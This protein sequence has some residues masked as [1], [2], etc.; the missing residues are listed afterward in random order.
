MIGVEVL[1]ILYIMYVSKAGAE[2]ML[3]GD[4]WVAQDSA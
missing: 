1:W 3:F 4:K 2:K